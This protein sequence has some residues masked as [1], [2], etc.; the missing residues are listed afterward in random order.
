[1]AN[2]YDLFAVS[3]NDTDQSFSFNAICS[4]IKSIASQSLAKI[5]QFIEGKSQGLNIVL[6][7]TDGTATIAHISTE[8]FSRL[9]ASDDESI[10][11]PMFSDASE[12]TKSISEEQL[13]AA[14]SS[15]ITQNEILMELTTA[16]SSSV[17]IE[18]LSTKLI[19]IKSTY[20]AKGDQQAARIIDSLLSFVVM[21]SDQQSFKSAALSW[22]MGLMGSTVDVTPT[23]DTSVNFGKISDFTDYSTATPVVAWANSLDFFVDWPAFSNALKKVTAP[24]VAAMTSL[25]KGIVNL[26]YKIYS[27]VKDLLVDPVA[28]GNNSVESFNTFQG[29]DDFV[30][31]FILPFNVPTVHLNVG[32]VDPNDKLQKMVSEAALPDIPEYSSWNNIC[33]SFE[34]GYIYNFDVPGAVLSIQRIHTDE[35]IYGL[36]F[37]VS[38][39]GP[40]TYPEIKD[41]LRVAIRPK[42]LSKKI[43]YEGADV[44]NYPIS[45]SEFTKGAFT[46][47]SYGWTGSIVGRTLQ[48]KDDD[49]I[50]AFGLTQASAVYEGFALSL[51]GSYK[52][53]PDNTD[54]DT[55]NTN[56]ITWY[57]RSS[58]PSKPYFEANW[59]P[60]CSHYDAKQVITPA[61]D[62]NIFKTAYANPDD[63]S[64]AP[65]GV[66]TAK[67]GQFLFSPSYGGW[68]PNANRANNEGWADNYWNMAPLIAVLVAYIAKESSYFVPYTKQLSYPRGTYRLL[69]TEDQVNNFSSFIR[70]SL[71]AAGVVAGSI[72]G[73]KLFK[74]LKSKVLISGA[75]LQ[76]YRMKFN[77][78]AAQ[79][80]ELKKLNRI[81]NFWNKVYGFVVGGVSLSA[82]SNA[83]QR[84]VGDHEEEVDANMI[85][86][87]AITGTSI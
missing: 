14:L 38:E 59:A 16:I 13:S 55:I 48:Y 22:L 51:L 33:N 65:T 56:L 30:D 21:D 20:I 81:A 24:I 43:V 75:T 7:S 49:H 54:T 58:L 72:I 29:R 47:L 23:G 60:S 12:G 28:Y 76:Q 15:S 52:Q 39:Y 63:V 46:S 50:V 1:M 10:L 11:V 31:S 77:G 62:L 34:V 61:D 42:V 27:K 45:V 87:N 8:E 68:L 9:M 4:S 82:I 32:H 41:Y 19:T 85:I 26:G 44:R 84:V 53:G 83:V 71:V 40:V 5:N 36:D 18:D 35:S 79:L 25:A 66:I 57:T 37:P 86:Y 17:S 3:L 80:K 2:L 78:S 67:P 70:G 74:S 6:P 73:A 69:T 64:S